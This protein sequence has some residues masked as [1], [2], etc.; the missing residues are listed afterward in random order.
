MATGTGPVPTGGHDVKRISKNLVTKTFGGL[1]TVMALLLLAGCFTLSVHPFYEA[2][3]VVREPSLLGV[4]SDPE[5]PQSETWQFLAG[6]G[7]EY[8][9][10]IREEDSLRIKPHMDGVF[11]AHLFRVGGQLYL[12]MMPEEPA[13]SSAFFM[14]HVLPAHSVW[15]VELAGKDLVLKILETDRLEAAM[16]AGELDLSFV[17]RD[18]LQVLTAT[19]AELRAM[20][21]SRG[22]DFFGEGEHLQ[23]I[24]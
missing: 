18:G 17:E 19:S 12:D 16:A 24:Q 22:A 7:D 10:V 13:G 1:M 9:L 20:L 21:L 14:S 4:W 6:G 15:Q 5:D 23:R 2:K 11:E 3:D 8:Q